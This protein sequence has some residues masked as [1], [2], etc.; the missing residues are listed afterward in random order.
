MRSRPAI[1]ISLFIVLVGLAWRVGQHL[2]TPPTIGL[3]TMLVICAAV[4][5][6]VPVRTGR[7]TA[8]PGRALV[9]MLVGMCIT[10]GHAASGWPACVYGVCGVLISL[11]AVPALRDKRSIQSLTAAGTVVALCGASTLA[12]M[13]IGWCL[14]D[15]PVPPAIGSL[16]GGLIPGA[17]STG[18]LLTFWTG[19]GLETV[20]LTFEGLGLYEIWYIT[21][22]LFAVTAVS[23]SGRASHRLPANLAI[24]LLYSAVRFIVVTA[25]AIEWEMAGL[26][27]HPVA[28]VVSWLPLALL[29]RVPRPLEVPEPVLGAGRQG[30]VIHVPAPALAGIALAFVLGYADPGNLKQGRVVVDE[31][32]SNWE[33]TRP[34]FDTT[35]LG[36][37][38]EYNY[39]CLMDY[40]SHSYEVETSSGGI[41]ESLLDSVD[42]LVIKTPTEPFKPD[43]LEA[44]TT[45]VGA[46]GGLLLVGDHT[47]LFGMT[48]FLN[49][50]ARR[51]GTGFRYDDSFD[52][53]S[54]GFSTFERPDVVFHPSVRGLREFEFLTSCTAV[55]DV[56][57]QPV[58][59]GCG[60][61]S[62]D[63]DYGHPNFFGNIT[64]DL[65]D[66]FGL[67]LQ[68]CSRRFGRGR[69]LLFTDS[70]CF[71]N[72][73]L[74]GP[75]RR[76]LLL[77]F[78]DYLNREGTKYPWVRPMALAAFGVLCALSVRGLKRLPGGFGRLCIAVCAGLAVGACVVSD[79]NTCVHGRLPEGAISPIVLFDIEHTDASLFNY[80]AVTR[81]P[82]RRGFEQFYLCS[83]RI[84]IYPTTGG[85]ADIKKLDP[86]GAVLIEPCTGFSEEELDWL[87]GYVRRGGRLLVLDSALNQRSTANQ[88]LGRFGMK[89]YLGADMGGGSVPGD[90]L[91][92]ATPAGSP[93]PGGVPAISAGLRIQGG[94]VIEEDGHGNTVVAAVRVGEGVIAVAVDSFRY[95][96]YVLGPVL[97]RG[98]PTALTRA[99]YRDACNLLKTVFLEEP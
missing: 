25:L 12:L 8:A 96:E 43:E 59:L 86:E 24:I 84:G 41:S 99:L 20:R 5:L 44:I 83:Q 32:H 56:R 52:L 57:T 76:E 29:L 19:R 54:T 65:C 16:A 63:V 58:M 85:V 22:A 38:A 7:G 73:C 61:G 74:F 27:W 30:G 46:G 36:I 68:A 64:Y 66:R 18:D 72:F 4:A 78:V 33:W 15:I 49:P 81:E 6:V 40:L 10:L 3:A 11:G 79:L 53:A 23:R 88:V 98:K 87:A 50:I 1:R 60:L 31:T 62:E 9:A 70:T 21:A 77:G 13:H 93:V 45:F 97:Q 51:F 55:G 90:S 26:L 69:V 42:V 82:G 28:A 71:S 80:M 34:P 91:L 92:R 2:V 95:S 35:S 94:Q 67:F 14:H 37:R 89:T 75:G 39:Y 47:N 48:D 17:G